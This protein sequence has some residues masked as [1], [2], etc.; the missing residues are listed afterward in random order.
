MP[1]NQSIFNKYIIK[2]VVPVEEVSFFLSAFLFATLSNRSDT[3]SVCVFQGAA[4]QSIGLED[5]AQ[6]VDAVLWV[7]PDWAENFWN[8]M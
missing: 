6:V 4:V 8:K 1:W 7:H 2:K 5:A 3:A